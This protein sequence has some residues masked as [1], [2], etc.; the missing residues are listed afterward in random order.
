MPFSDG[1]WGL[2]DGT[3]SDLAGR[4]QLA[5]QVVADGWRAAV[6]AMLSHPRTDVKEF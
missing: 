3:E 4:L 2:D 5:V 1:Y 6:L